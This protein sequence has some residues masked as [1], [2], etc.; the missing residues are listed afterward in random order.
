MFNCKTNCWIAL[1]VLLAIAASEGRAALQLP[2]PTPL[3]SQQF[4]NF[5]VYSLPFLDN[6]LGGFSVQSSPGLIDNGVVP[7]TGAGGP[8]S[9]VVNNNPPSNQIDNAYPAPNGG[10]GDPYFG[11]TTTI[12]P[13]NGPTNDGANTW[14]ASVSAL[15]NFLSASNGQLVFFFNLNETGTQNNLAGI[16]LLAWAEVQLIDD[17]GANATKT[18]FL[19]AANDP[20]T[21]PDEHAAGLTASQNLGGPEPNPAL[22]PTGTTEGTLDA[23]WGTVHGTITVDANTGAFLHFGPANGSE[24]VPTKNIN[25]NL[26]ANDAAFAAYNQELNDLVLDPFSGYTRL[27]IDL[28]LSRINNGFEQVFLLA[29]TT[30]NT[31]G[32]VPE[33]PSGFVWLGLGTVAGAA[34]YMRTKM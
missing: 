8:G 27:A 16:D 34:L 25:Q 14:D 26:G 9:P 24:G 4:G 3:N 2:A 1:G 18:Y 5:N 33:L 21:V 22:N 31:P 30:V 29:D 10:G 20:L 11:T 17:T 12:D 19:S 15:R 32:V 13:A 23:Q 28:R 7:L 6:L